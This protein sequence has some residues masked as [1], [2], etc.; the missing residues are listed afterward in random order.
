MSRSTQA[1]ITVFALAGALAGIVP[2]PVVPRRIVRAIRGAMAFDVSSAHGLALT[3]EARE[4]L[5]ETSAAGFAPPLAKDALAW[6]AR[7]ALARFG[8]Y[9]TAVAPVKVA[10]ETA[11]FG[12]LFERYLTKYRAAGPRG[13]VVRIDGEEALAIRRVLDRAVERAIRPGL[14]ADAE[15][16]V[17]PPEDHRGSLQRTIDT[18]MINAARLPEW[19][20]TRLDAALDDVMSAMRDG[21]GS[22]A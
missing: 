19:I 14:P 5:S 18:A 21:D 1:R 20:A 4:I 9:A 16:L 3:P 11:A 10:L 8:P 13:R 7:K 15:G 6:V 2:L 22:D 17:D 12:R